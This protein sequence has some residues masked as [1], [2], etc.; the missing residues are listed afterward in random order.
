M[1]NYLFEGFTDTCKDQCVKPTNQTSNCKP[2]TYDNPDWDQFYDNVKKQDFWKNTNVNSPSYNM[3]TFEK[4]K[5]LIDNS[6][7]VCPW[8]CSNTSVDA[9]NGTCIY[10]SDC[11]K[12][13]PQVIFNSST[14]EDLLGMTGPV[15]TDYSAGNGISFND[16]A[17]GQTGPVN[18]MFDT[19]DYNHYDSSD[20]TGYDEDN[21][22]LK[23]RI[24]PP[25]CPACPNIE[26]P[27]SNPFDKENKIKKENCVKKCN[28]EKQPEQ[29]S[30]IPQQSNFSNQLSI[31]PQQPNFTNQPIYKNDYPN[32][33]YPILPDFTTFGV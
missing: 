18:D 12:C 27:D 32:V 16:D 8:N 29:P 4:P 10:D 14:S 5:Q 20:I 7:M 25:I 11:F 15:E 30:I 24:V 21:Y 33:P 23:T 3:I 22:I 19:E 2:Y 28:V 6:R 26:F 9:P 17:T 1:N 13:E 31:L